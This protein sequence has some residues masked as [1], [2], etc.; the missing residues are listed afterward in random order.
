[1]VGFRIDE[2]V[3][4]G[5]PEL[6][7]LEITCVDT[8][9]PIYRRVP[10]ES[11]LPLKLF[12]LNLT[13]IP[14][15]SLEERLASRFGVTYQAVE[16]LPL[17][18]VMGIARG[19]ANASVYIS[20]RISLVRFQRALK[21]QGHKLITLMR[22]PFEELAERLLLARFSSEMQTPSASP[23]DYRDLLKPITDLATAV[24][25]TSDEALAAAF[26]D[27]TFR[28]REL[29][30]N[31]F[32]RVIACQPG[33]EAYDPHLAVA[34]D[35]LS[36]MDL[37][38]TRAHYDAF[39]ADLAELLGEDLLGAHQL[40]EISHVAQL[41]A[42]LSKIKAVQELLW[43]DTKLYACVKEAITGVLADT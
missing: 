26:G 1:M 2:T 17:D 39:K 9:V 22:D 31:P 32:V 14:Q 29:L 37:V 6:P 3:V 20:G 8:S 30:S 23:F 19:K 43:L 38:G 16:R 41:G 25:I 10:Q 42:R 40:V 21:S 24:D 35:N 13:A 36:L 15:M 7:E 34:L 12:H 27:L 18:V 4:P 28:Q 33:E 11:V 5:L